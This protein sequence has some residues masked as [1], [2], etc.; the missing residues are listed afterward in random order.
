MLLL[1]WGQLKV[2]LLISSHSYSAK[3]SQNQWWKRQYHRFNHARIDSIRGENAKFL[4][5]SN[6][7]YI[8]WNWQQ[9]LI[10][11]I[12]SVREPSPSPGFTCFIQ[13]WHHV[14]CC[15]FHSLVMA[16]P[17]GMEK[18]WPGNGK[19]IYNGEQF[20]PPF[21]QFMMWNEVTFREQKWPLKCCQHPN[22]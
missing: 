18:P 20:K 11:W 3:I 19:C 22:I 14:L 21:Y 7:K 16:F 12:F 15:L 8:E 13:Y 6:S 9:Y 17:D 10:F 1:S 5:L 4:I 2:L